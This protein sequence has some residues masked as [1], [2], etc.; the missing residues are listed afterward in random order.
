MALGTYP[1]TSSGVSMG[2]RRGVAQGRGRQPGPPAAGGSK[3]TRDKKQVV[4]NS[5]SRRTLP[6]PQPQEHRNLWEEQ[7]G[8][9]HACGLVISWGTWI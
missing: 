1:G 9:R 8:I 7:D 2:Q 4:G 3:G 6:P 5:S